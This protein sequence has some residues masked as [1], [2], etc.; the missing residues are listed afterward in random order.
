MQQVRKNALV[1]YAASSMFDLVD[2]IERYP[3]FLPW[4]SGAKVLS[5]SEAEVTATVTIGLA[6]LNAPFTTR[7]LNQR[8]GMIRLTLVDGPFQSLEG[9]W[10]FK[11]LAQD[12]CKVELHL[13]Y[14]LRSGLL[15]AALAPAFDQITRSLV[16][17]FVRR[18]EAKLG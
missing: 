1:P 12:A 18:A 8:P 15:G 16:D 10:H 9:A 11:A 6:G 17:A 5:R 13:D 4:C 7:N 14:E 2:D 3:A